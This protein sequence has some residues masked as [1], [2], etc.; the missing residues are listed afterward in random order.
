MAVG[1]LKNTFSEFDKLA[2]QS[3]AVKLRQYE[4]TAEARKRTVKRQLDLGII[5]QEQYNKRVELIDKDLDNK[6]AEIEYKQAKRQ[7]AMAIVKAITDTAVSIVNLWTNPG[8]PMA[9]PLS[10]I[11]GALGAAQLATISRQ[12]L[13][14]RGAEEGY[15]PNLVRRQQDNK[16]FRTTGT[17]KMETGLFTK[18]RLLVGEGPGDMPEMV[19]DKKAFAKLTPPT[20]S[21]LLGEI[22]AI[23]GLEN[24][25]YKKG[26]FYTGSSRANSTSNGNDEMLELVKMA[27]N[28][29]AKNTEVLEDIKENGIAA[30]VSNKDMS[31]MKNLKKG[32]KEFDEL[33]SKSKVS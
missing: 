11:V 33:I 7:K 8:Y 19:I 16:L 13:P 28:V 21:A 22:S 4:K 14:A 30:F 17:S 2:S 25:Y 3:E 18:P 5:N 27:L 31:S 23:K 12:P 20:K 10:I 24:G 1:L 29:V 6:K 32:I 26:T 9:I 15:Y